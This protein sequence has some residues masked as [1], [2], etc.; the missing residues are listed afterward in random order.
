MKGGLVKYV[1]VILMLAALPATVPAQPADTDS[2]WI[3]YYNNVDGWFAFLGPQRAMKIHPPDF[4]LSYPV[5]V[6]SLKAWFYPGMGSWTDSVITFRIYGNDGSTLIWESESLTVPVTYWLR[7]GLPNPVKIDS[8]DFYIAITHRRVDPYAHPYLNDDTGTAIHSLYGSPGNW[9]VAGGGEYCFFAWVT[10]GMTGV[11]EGR[12]TEPAV[13]PG[14][15]CLARGTLLV[16]K[17]AFR[18]PK[19]AMVMLDVSGRKVMDLEPG[20]NDV[21][22]LSPGIYFCRTSDPGLTGK[23]VLER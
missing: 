21:S 15:P 16:P 19:S 4:G 2:S 13:N 18:N 7:Y 9:T 14:L 8:A 17:S 23:V 6:E 3:S 12:W 20:A 10:E 5:Q 11:R 1:M 22:R